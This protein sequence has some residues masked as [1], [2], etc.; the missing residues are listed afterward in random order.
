MKGQPNFWTAAMTNIYHESTKHSYWSVRSNPNYLDWSKQPV[1]FKIYPTTNPFMPL[2]MNTPLHAFIYRIGG[3]NA[4][5]VYPG[6]EYYLR[7]IP[8]AGAL[9]PVEIYFQSR[10]VDGLED[11]IY[12][13]SVAE[14]GLRF[15]YPLH[16][17][18]GI[19]I[20]FEK[21]RQIKG[22]I[23]L[24]STIYYRSSWKYKN[25][26][27]RYC[28]LD[29]GH[30][31]GA[32][33]ASSF[34]FERAY[35]ILYNFD[36]EALNEAFGFENWEFFLSSA[37]VGI[38]MEKEAKSFDM[39]LP[40]VDGTR[41]FEQNSVIEDAYKE[42]L[43]LKNC[44][45]NFRFPKFP[46]EPKR[47]EE[48]V[49]QRR[50]IRD[51]EG[52]CIKKEQFEFIL[53]WMRSPIPSDCD[54]KVDIWYVVNRVDGLQPGL[55]KNSELVKEGDFHKKA[56][57]LCLEQALGSQSAVTFFLISHGENY[58]P[59]YQKAGL[60]GHRCYIASEYLGI[61]CSGIGAYYDDEVREFLQTDDMVLYALAIGI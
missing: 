17:D 59:L 27:F 61:G 23:F 50:S 41:T 33:E 49:M 18:E 57:Y 9:Y 39:K 43:Y 38:P 32:L 31:L 12:H 10:G 53:S 21:K 44:K 6:V 47:L 14:N 45:A 16:E 35:Y 51:F 2:D 55:Y 15:L 19:E 30:A 34:L 37:V 1:P 11:G 46:F 20:F 28:L 56:G 26:A 54:E 42:T 8:S 52:K 25:R 3:I 24:F 48:A 36:K 40:F 4:K 22:F 60:I 7:T 29:T 5:K 58:Q 13:F